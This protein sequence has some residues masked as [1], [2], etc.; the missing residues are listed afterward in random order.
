[1]PT[2][3]RR[4]ALFSALTDKLQSKGI[5]VVNK[6]TLKQFKTKEISAIFAALPLDRS[7]LVVLPQKD[8]NLQRAMANLP[9]VKIVTANVLHPYEILKYKTVVLLQD[10]LPVIEETFLNKTTAPK[11][12]DADQDAEVKPKAPAKATAKKATSTTKKAK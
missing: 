11:A 9:N 5:V 4:A 1:M 10:A 2:T 12:K 7:I 8:Q 3:M 6:L